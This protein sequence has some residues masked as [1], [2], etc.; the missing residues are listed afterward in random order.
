MNR[1]ARDLISV[2][3]APPFAPVVTNRV[4]DAARLS[5]K[6]LRVVV[7]NAAGGRRFDDIVACLKRPPLRDADLL[8]LCEVDL[9][10]RRSGG[11]AVASDLATA[12]N[13]SCAF[14][15]EFGVSWDGG[16]IVGYM[17]NAILSAVPFEQVE[18]IPMPNPG[19]KWKFRKPSGRV[20]LSGMPTGLVTSIRF[21][22]MP[23]TVGVAHLHSR[24]S[25]EERE[26]Q[27]ATYLESFPR[28]GR[29]I[30]GGDLNST[31]LAI[32]N[33]CAMLKVAS[34]SLLT[35]HRFKAPQSREPLFQRIRDHGLEIDGV[36][37][38]NRSTFTFSKFVPPLLRPKLDWLAVRGLRPVAGSAKVIAPRL[39]MF[40]ERASDHDFIV[41]DVEF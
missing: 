25:P 29:A 12:M 1:E 33:A 39:S 40:A 36:N 13:L 30:F 22:E 15:P 18:A 14:V 8:L 9:N 20:S 31:T 19:P 7:F 21:G 6:R 3:I 4:A 34:L 27:M 24:C 16:R 23:I 35:P 37:V 10:L 11:R 38:A 2:P 32:E 5:R 28:S 17:G 26:R 41:A